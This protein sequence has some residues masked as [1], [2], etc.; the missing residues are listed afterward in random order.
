MPRAARA[1]PGGMVFHV[2]NRG[3]GRMGLFS[4]EEDY[5][6]FEA[7]LEETRESRPVRICGYCLMPNHWHFVLWPEHDGDLAAFTQQPKHGSGP[8]YGDERRARRS[9]SNCSAIGRWRIRRAGAISSTSRRPRPSWRGFAAAWR[10]ASR[11]EP[12]NGSAGRPNA[13]GWNPRFEHRTGPGRLRPTNDSQNKRS[14]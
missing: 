4:K 3:V 14:R 12:S 2:L 11:T 10:A 1:A 8:A 6:A 7:L 13:S 9:K 5:A